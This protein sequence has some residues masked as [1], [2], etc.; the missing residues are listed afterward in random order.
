MNLS[1][2]IAR[3]YLFSKKS[4]NAINIISAISVCGVALATMAMVC[5]MSV[6]NGFEEL[7]ASFFTEID[8]QLKI[9]P[10]K[11]KTMDAQDPLLEKIAEMPEV[12]VF[13]RTLEEQALIAVDDKQVM[14]TIKGVEDNFEQL[15]DIRNILY[16]PG[17]FILHADV[18]EYGVLGIQLAMELG[19]GASFDVPLQVYVPRR[20]EKIN[21]MNPL[22]GFRQDELYSPGVVFVVKQAKYDA[23]YVLTSLGFAG[24]LFDMVDRISAVELKI[25][26]DYSVD[27]V[28]EQ[29]C[30]ILG[31]KYRVLDRYEQQDDVFKIMKVEKLIAYFFLSFILFIACFNII[32]SVSMLI[33]EKRTDVVTLQNLGLLKKDV[34]NIFRFEG[35]MISGIGAF[36]GI[37]VGLLL[38]MIQ[39]QYGLLTLGNSAGSMVVDAYPVSVHVGDLLVVFATVIIVSGLAIWWP[40]RYLVRQ[41]L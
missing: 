21:L 40:V 22:T 9:V 14:V 24:R 32:G 12:A 16:G 5:T 4:H 41:F 36:I 11:G 2:Y 18:L 25:K 17:E 30:Q 7:V 3:H 20:G 28:K 34:I 15:T 31:N 27:K 10:D 33:I 37:F 23:N 26:P 8:A 35:V 29:I 1:S 6:F 38:C 13:S 19:V 39:Q